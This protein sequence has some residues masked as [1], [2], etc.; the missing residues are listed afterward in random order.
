MNSKDKVISKRLDK[1]KDLEKDIVDTAENTYKITQIVFEAT[2]LKVNIQELLYRG[3]EFLPQKLTVLSI[4]DKL[5]VQLQ[6]Q[7]LSGFRRRHPKIVIL[8]SIGIKRFIGDLAEW[9]SFLDSYEA[10]IDNFSELS[11]LLR[12]K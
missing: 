3:D 10:A 8:A 2:E 12:F 7:V 4:N 6:H 9:P 1:L 11:D 5:N